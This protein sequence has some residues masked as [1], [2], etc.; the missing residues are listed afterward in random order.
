M[1]RTE[2]EIARQAA[3]QRCVELAAALQRAERDLETVRRENA[4]LRVLSR[5]QQEDL[6]ALQVRVAGML[7]GSNEVESGRALA[8]ALACLEDMGAVQA[9]LR[10][11]VQGFGE[12]VIT[13]LDVL[14][15]SEALRREVMDRFRALVRSCER[16]GSLPSI[17]AG[18]GGKPEGQ[19]ESRV[20]AVNDDLQVVVFD[21]GSGQGVRAGSTWTVWSDG[22]RIARVQVVDVRPTLSAAVPIEG[23]LGSIAPGAS[24]RGAE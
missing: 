10:A 24:V 9:R 18:R 22:R 13:A 21:S 20:L 15:P 3:E 12:Y 16:P 2:A 14:Q 5:R 1:A 19:R 4:D 17:V 6:T 11:E 8:G 7:T 23:R